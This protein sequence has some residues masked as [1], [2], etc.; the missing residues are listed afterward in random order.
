MAKDYV[1]DG[2]TGELD[3]GGNALAQRFDLPEAMVPERKKFR[4]GTATLP[5]LSRGW[6]QPGVLKAPRGF[7]G[8]QDI[9]AK[10]GSLGTLFGLNQ[11]FKDKPEEEVERVQE[12]TQT[13]WKPSFK[14]EEPEPPKKPKGPK[15][16]DF[17]KEIMIEEILN[18][19]K[20]LR[21]MDQ[22]GKI[23]FIKYFEKFAELYHGGNASAAARELN[24]VGRWGQQPKNFKEGEWI[25]SIA[26][27]A[28]HKL[29]T[30]GRGEVGDVLTD[31]TIR[32]KTIGSLTDKLSKDPL[33]LNIE[34]EDDEY[35]NVS[36]TLRKLGVEPTE[37]N[38]QLFSM[39]IREKGA[40]GASPK[41]YK[42][43]ITVRQ[44]DSGV[45]GKPLYNLKDIVSNVENF[46]LKSGPGSGP[47][48]I[49][50]EYEPAFSWKNR[51]KTEKQI[52]PDFHLLKN[53]FQRWRYL[54]QYQKGDE[55]VSKLM[56]SG[57]KMK[58][59]GVKFKP[60]TG[61]NPDWGHA[62]NLRAIED[63]DFIKNSKINQNKLYPL[64]SNVRQDTDINQ[65]ILLDEF[66]AKDNGLMKKIDSFL[67][68]NKVWDKETIKKAEQINSR[69]KNLL[70]NKYERLNKWVKSKEKKEPYLSGQQNT[71]QGLLL[72]IKPG[73]KITIEDIIVDKTYFKPGKHSIGKINVINDKAVK[74][75]D[76]SPKQLEEYQNSIIDQELTYL[77]QMGKAANFPK[78]L[79]QET[80]ESMLYGWEGGPEGVSRKGYLTKRGIPDFA[81]G[82][83]VVP[84]IEYRDGT[85][86]SP[87][88]P[89]EKSYEDILKE[90][91]IQYN[92]PNEEGFAVKD[93]LGRLGDIVDPRNYPYY[94]SKV[95]KGIMEAAEF[96]VRFPG[97]AGQLIHDVATGPGWKEQGLDFIKNVSPGWGWSEKVGLDSLIDE[98]VGAMKERGAS[99]APASL[100]GV[101]NLG[102]DIAM[103][104]GYVYGAAKFAKFMKALGQTPDKISDF[105]KKI[106]DHL[107]STGQS[108]RDF[109]TLVGTVGAMGAIKAMGL[110]KVFKMGKVTK[111][112]DD[113]IPMLKGTESIMPKWFP[114]FIQRIQPKLLYEG[115]GI[116]TF[117]GTD[118]F[119]PG[120]E[121]T[122]IGDDYTVSGTN[123]YEGS[124][125]INYEGPRWL[126][127]EPGQKPTYFKGEFQVADDA[128]HM[129]DP[130]GGVHWDQTI[131]KEVD[132]ILGGNGRSMEEFAT[133][134]K[135]EGLTKGEKQVDWAEGRAQQ[136][137]D[138]AREADEG[139]TK[140][141]E[142]EWL[143][144]Y[145]DDRMPDDF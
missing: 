24:P 101:L 138:E 120:I 48:T 7:T 100:G 61:L 129:V 74:L 68:E 50:G 22:E 117:K 98:Q 60:E 96:S 31:V 62:F 52:D 122:K 94:G 77:A 78:E 102:A 118:D 90:L 114:M 28:G 1:I 79:M 33:Y 42:T 11:L 82:G 128:P 56:K 69:S 34:V 23:D 108:K 58:I 47:K 75:K 135:I 13:D 35:Y 17:A 26:R 5:Y 39:L 97:A 44:K 92:I 87:Q 54:G 111:G 80:I 15:V 49:K 116:S 107:D 113:M 143:G 86:M 14:P 109:M 40:E 139:L 65:K 140:L 95:G 53:K 9:L 29:K 41:S 88:P 124:W 93:K 130:D 59:S 137:A 145:V 30:V 12:V 71:I 142:N 21:Q 38:R 73:K 106:I 8:M 37:R 103:P 123:A 83:P 132:D 136:A 64:S 81:Q 57:K 67:K 84:R 89:K 85:R 63:F 66:K 36:N 55:A 99:D 127:I 104:L 119:L 141:D 18:R 125:N 134:T 19:K 72:K 76:L 25:R 27:R 110:D 131:H 32:D 105:N 121:V 126:E 91:Q 51:L 144:N 46:A 115:D 112:V 20:N 133:G 43:N 10:E 2:G 6:S 3:V 16:G 70:K 4:A 45:P